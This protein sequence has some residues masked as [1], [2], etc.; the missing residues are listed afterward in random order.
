MSKIEMTTDTI[1]LSS[2]TVVLS[3]GKRFDH[4]EIS[5]IV[6]IPKEAIDEKKTKITEWIIK[7][8]VEIEMLVRENHDAMA[9]LCGMRQVSVNQKCESLYAV[10]ARQY[11]IAERIKRLN[12]KILQETG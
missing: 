7:E 2:V 4:N 3:S 5:S 12:R 10:S 9:L 11:E 8:I 1:A 6:L